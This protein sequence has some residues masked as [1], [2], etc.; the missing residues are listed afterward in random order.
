MGDIW[1]PQHVIEDCAIYYGRPVVVWEGA[2]TRSARYGG[3]TE[4]KG[5][6]QH[7]TASP[8]YLARRN[9]IYS[10]YNDDAAPEYNIG[11]D[12]DGT[13]NFLAAGGVNSSGKGGAIT[14]GDGSVVPAGAANY[15]LIAVSYGNNGVGELYTKEALLSGIVVTAELLWYFGKQ[16]GNCTAHKE[17]CGPGTVSP[18]R[19]I[20]TW[21]PWESGPWGDGQDWGGPQGRIDKFRGELF[22]YLADPVRYLQVAYGESPVPPPPDPTPPPPQPPAPEPNPWLE[23]PAN[24]VWGMKPFDTGKPNLY[25]G[26]ESNS[27]L[28]P[29]IRYLQGVLHCK[30]NAN[31][32]V[33]GIYGNQTVENVKY[34][35]ATHGLQVGGGVGPSTWPVIDGIALS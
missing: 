8:G 30:V 18:G 16:A 35:Q 34:V 13:I 26:C 32:V 15:Q 19:K 6:I 4:V 7:H 21:G 10:T 20:D 5:V 22:W 3:F 12:P 17:W 25:K 31:V 23:D 28:D 1:I 33:D 24:C 9:W 27:A 14:L 29:F 11:I 2:A